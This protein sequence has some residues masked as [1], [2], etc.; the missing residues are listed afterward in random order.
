MDIWNHFHFSIIMNN[1]VMNLC[2][3][4]F[5]WSVCIFLEYIYLGVEPLG[6]IVNLCK[7][8]KSAFQRGSTLLLLIS[9]A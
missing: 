7:F 5:V 2:A 9:S 6:H 8:L 1:A 3:Q 4:I